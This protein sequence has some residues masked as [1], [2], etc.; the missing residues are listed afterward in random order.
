[1]PGS[2]QS[3][4]DLQKMLQN[5]ARLWARRGNADTAPSYILVWSEGAPRGAMQPLETPTPALGRGIQDHSASTW[6]LQ[7]GSPDLNVPAAGYVLP[8]GHLGPSSHPSQETTPCCTAELH[9]WLTLQLRGSCPYV[10]WSFNKKF[11]GKQA[12][13]DLASSTNKLCPK[14]PKIN[15]LATAG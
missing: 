2:S 5:W 3:W 9:H 13:I 11:L 15:F 12:G 14:K 7:E 4:V 6:E 1:M 8:W 10:F